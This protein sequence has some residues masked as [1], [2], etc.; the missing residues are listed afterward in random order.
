[1][2]G[3]ACCGLFTFA[4]GKA[5][6]SLLYLERRAYLDALNAT[7]KGVKVVRPYGFGPW[8]ARKKR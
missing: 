7:V 2:A 3:C 8:I 1:V 5:D 4:G 6:D